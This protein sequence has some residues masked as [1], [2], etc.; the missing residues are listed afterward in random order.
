[1]ATTTPTHPG[2]TLHDY[3]EERDAAA[4]QRLELDCAQSLASDFPFYIV[5]YARLYLSPYHH[6]VHMFPTSFTLVAKV[7]D[8]KVIGL[9]S[10]AIKKVYYDNKPIIAGYIFD[11]RVHD[12]HRRQRVGL[13]LAQEMEKRLI[14]KGAALLY[15]VVYAGN[16]A[17]E[18]LFRG[19]LGYKIATRKAI[20]IEEVSSKSESEPLTSVSPEEAE[21]HLT[22]AYG[23]KDCTPV[24]FHDL[25]TSP[26]YLGTYCARDEA[27]NRAEASLWH[28]TRHTAKAVVEV[29]YP[30]DYLQKSHFYSLFLVTAIVGV[31]LGVLL[32]LVVYDWI[33]PQILKLLWGSFMLLVGLLIVEFLWVFLKHW[34]LAST[35]PK[36]EQKISLFGLHYTGAPE[37]KEARYDALIGGLKRV[38][39]QSADMV[40][41]TVDSSD[42]DR[43][44]FAS[45]MHEILYLQKK[46]QAEYWNSWTRSLFSDPRDLV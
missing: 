9:V 35:H 6:R 32:T 19:D 15:A 39:G 27:G 23:D 31:V 18:S 44:C 38:C 5:K 14:A 40:C 43:H 7:D 1:M 42:P 37:A 25:F 13:A 29:L 16:R 20:H 10:G 17:A 28:T 3:N 36:G 24:S 12:G 46:L 8:N 33:G 22:A 30:V 45:E 26:E 4:I 41:W 2:F 11:L 21:A 34:R